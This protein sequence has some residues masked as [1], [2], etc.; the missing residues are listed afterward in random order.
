MAKKDDDEPGLIFHKIR[1]KLFKSYLPNAKGKYIARTNSERTLTVSDICGIMKTRAGF[2]GKY[3]DLLENVKQFNK[4]WAYQLCDGFAVT[5]GYFTTYPVIGGVF[6][7]V[8]EMHDH[9]KHPV[10]FK[11]SIRAKLKDLT[12]DIKVILEG[13]S[14]SGE[15]IDT[16]TD[17][18][19]DSV[20]GIFIPGN[21]FSLHGSKI[22]LE[23]NDPSVGLYFVP[24]DDPSKAVKVKRIGKNNPTEITGIAP[25][26]GYQSNRIEVRTQFSGMSG[27]PVKEVRV[28]TSHF[29]LESS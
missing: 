17:Q 20:N 21:M 27:R 16:F 8:N 19:E 10:G 12:K 6:D 29:T 1:A 2:T 11:F 3:E 18:E 13:L 9:K 15:Y 28:I 25:D 22:K 7:G 5:N 4:E 24:V 26:T 14:D 23:G